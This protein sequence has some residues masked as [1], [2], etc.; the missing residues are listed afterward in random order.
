MSTK[1]SWGLAA[2]VAVV[3]A[4]VAAGGV[5]LANR[6]GGGDH[7]AVVT[8]VADS[9]TPVAATITI[10]PRANET[11]ASPSTASGSQAPAMTADAVWSA[12]QSSVG[13]SVTDVPTGVTVELGALTLPNF[14]QGAT[15]N[16]TYAAHNELAYGFRHAPSTCRYMSTHAPADPGTCVV[17]TFLDAN[18]GKLVDQT[19]QGLTGP[20]A[21]A[22]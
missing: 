7:D 10:D 8:T 3:I 18:T 5:V 16:W 13:S 9:A 2:V 17:W 21:S 14:D 11:F 20:L 12:W 6:G 22:S 4:G 1:T 15:A 19:E